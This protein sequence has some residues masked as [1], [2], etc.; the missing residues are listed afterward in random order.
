[1]IELAVGS[2]AES[3]EHE[4]TPRRLVR[5]EV[6]LHVID[7]LLLVDDVARLELHDGDDSLTEAL[8]GNPD[9]RRIAHSTHLLKL[10]APEIGA[11]QG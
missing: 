1:M 2:S 4:D 5:R 11:E 10:L 9:D 7:Q 3:R 8:V 6:R